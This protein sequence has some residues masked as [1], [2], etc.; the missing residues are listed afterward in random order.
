MKILYFG[1]SWIEDFKLDVYQQKVVDTLVAQG[2]EVQVLLG[3][4]LSAKE[5]I[6]GF[7]VNIDK[8]ARYIRSEGFDLVLC[9]NNAG[10]SEALR[11]AVDCPFVSWS[12]DEFSHIFKP[13]ED[14]WTVLDE[15]THLFVTST[16]CE[17][18]YAEMY[19]NFK[20]NIHFVP[21]CTSFD[22]FKQT[23]F[24]AEYD[25]SFIGSS[26]HYAVADNLLWKNA[27][28][29][30][31]DVYLAVVEAIERLKQ[32][33]YHDF[34]KT[35]EELN[36]KPV[37][38]DEGI[39]VLSFKMHAANMISNNERYQIIHALKDFKTAVFGNVLWL[40][41]TGY[42]TDIAKMFRPYDSV[43]KFQDLVNVYQTSRISISIPQL[44]VGPALQYRVSDIL[45]SD[46]L[47]VTKYFP[48]SDLYRVFG[49]DCPIPTYRDEKDL[50]RI[51]KYYLENEQERKDLVKKCHDLLLSERLTFHYRLNEIFA[52]VGVHGKP[53]PNGGKIVYLSHGRF[54]KLPVRLRRMHRHFDFFRRRAVTAL[55][56]FSESVL[57][58]FRGKKYI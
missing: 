16:E 10:N 15:K 40:K 28:T 8:M 21:H 5:G 37:L 42:T 26:L 50:V 44:Q 53:Q 47:L 55:G 58:L 38:E 35:I 20:K 30:K 12:S 46:S 14:R 4:L 9:K 23:P 18:L 32:D 43:K 7:S 39:S 49:K 11:K 34:D 51:C 31:K 48:D 19:P 3:N 6:L 36:L 25:V 57:T 56:K 13:D 45:A 29:K 17:Q 27:T 1:F 54:L 24:R 52:T 33:Y 22:E 41:S 2:H